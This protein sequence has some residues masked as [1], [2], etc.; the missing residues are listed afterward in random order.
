M[1]ILKKFIRR[2]KKLSQSAHF[3]KT[4]LLAVLA[5]L[6][7]VGTVIIF[8][9]RAAGPFASI[10]AEQGTV[11]SPAAIQ[12]GDA[13]ASGGS[14]VRFGSQTAGGCPPFP[15][16]PD[17]NCTGWQHTG[18][19]L[20][21]YS[22][23]REIY[24]DNTV[25][26]GKLISNGLYIRASNVTIKRSQINGGV[27]L[28]YAQA[29]N[30]LLEDVEINA[31]NTTYA[32]IGA[33]NFTCRRCNIHGGGQG[34]NGYSFTIEDSWIHDLYGEGT[35][36]SEAILAAYSKQSA[37]NRMIHNRLEG[38]YGAQ[39]VWNPSDGGMSASVAIY[40][41]GDTW[42]SQSHV[43]ME[44]NLLSVGNS[45]RD[46]AN[47]CLYAG[48]P[49]SINKL[50]YSTFKDNV[51]KRNSSTGKCG[52]NP[53]SSADNGGVGNCQSGNRYEDGTPISINGNWPACGPLS[54]MLF[55]KGLRPVSNFDV[56]F[57]PT[58]LLRAGL[59]D[60]ISLS[61]YSSKPQALWL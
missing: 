41:H 39:G 13:S 5:A 22:G 55:G 53:V 50:S 42:G 49:D 24:T 18:V 56:D 43:W 23:P 28:G 44:K 3:D 45:G 38:A 52:N 31:G 35:V 8:R 29:H 32:A 58:K 54:Y 2:P 40:T 14:S 36:H 21:P 1:K 15:A 12:S 57:W 26:D 10:E 46:L 37:P 34:I 59:F 20:T 17:A 16:F 11:S 48:T 61:I 19:T 4:T 27:D 47:Y 30:I 51:F 33:A 9:G 60:I 6:V 25:I 7:L